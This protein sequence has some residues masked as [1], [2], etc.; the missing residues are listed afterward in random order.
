MNT[1]DETAALL[2]EIHSLRAQL[3]NVYLV[4]MG[5]GA[6]EAESSAMWAVLG[7]RIR[8][9]TLKEENRRLRVRI[10][11]LTNPR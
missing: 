4:S 8:L 11:E 2:D 3:N 6:T 10:A 7:L 9:D 1:V 5:V